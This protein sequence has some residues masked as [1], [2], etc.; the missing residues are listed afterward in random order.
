M[1]WHNDDELYIKYG[2]EEATAATA[3]SYR[4]AGPF[5][6]IELTVDYTDFAASAAIVGSDTAK[7]PDGARI[8]FVEVECVTAFDSSGDNF[9]FNFGLQREDRSTELD[10]NGLIAAMPQ[11]NVDAAGERNV[12]DI[13]H[14]Y[15][16][17]LVGTT[18]ANSGY[19]TVDYDTAAPTA[20]AA[21]FRVYY[22]MV[23]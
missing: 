18:L 5:E 1:A 19:F 3:G 6:V 20:G 2:T 22:R 13:A 15:A 23:E 21:I 17:V 4:M 7:L 12:V 14:T 16:G 9:V 8:F 10:Y 11:A